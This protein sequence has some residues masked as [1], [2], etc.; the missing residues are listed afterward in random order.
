[1]ISIILFCDSYR[2]YFHPVHG[3][4]EVRIPLM[5][6]NLSLISLFKST[7]LTNYTEKILSRLK[8]N[9]E[10]IIFGVFIQPM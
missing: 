1:M 7:L 6:E 2:L 9:D 5:N 8:P 10:I 4:D 3:E